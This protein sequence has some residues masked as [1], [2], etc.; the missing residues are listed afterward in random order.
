M[1]KVLRLESTIHVDLLCLIHE[2]LSR[3]T[4]GETFRR[5]NASLPLIGNTIRVSVLR[6]NATFAQRVARKS[7][8]IAVKLDVPIGVNRRR[9][10]RD[11]GKLLSNPGENTRSVAQFN[12]SVV[13]GSPPIG[14][15]AYKRDKWHEYRD[16]ALCRMLAW[17]TICIRD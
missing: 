13:A 1:R 4:R 2:L 10:T 7:A 9:Y 5:V 12:P 11:W 3:I 17:K 6:L 15:A 14:L 16:G 8:A